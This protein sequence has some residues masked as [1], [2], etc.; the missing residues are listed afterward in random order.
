MGVTP[1]P[2]PTE[3][4]DTGGTIGDASEQDDDDTDQDEFDLEGDFPDFDAGIQEFVAIIPLHGQVFVDYAKAQSEARGLDPLAVA[5]N[6]YNEGIGGGIG[7]GGTRYGPWQVHDGGALPRQYWDHTNDPQVNTWA[8]SKAGINYVLDAMAGT[9]ARGKSGADAVHA[10]VYDFEKPLDKAVQYTK[11]LRTY[12]QLAS[13]GGGAWTFLAGQAKG[14]KVVASEP[15]PP[16]TTTKPAGSVGAAGAWRDLCGTFNSAV[17][18]AGA[19][20]HTVGDRLAG[21]VS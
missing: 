19:F 6:Y 5:A 17:P 14:P 16:P 2:P 3:Q 20:L 12:S 15:K 9:S 7:R 13:M 10:I 8:W 11:R 21:R 18:G 4:T 1:P